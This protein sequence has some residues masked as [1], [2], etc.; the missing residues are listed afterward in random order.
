MSTRRRFMKQAGCAVAATAL[1]RYAFGAGR[2]VD[3]LK[4]LTEE[5]MK[6]ASYYKKTDAGADCELCPNYCILK[7]G[8]LSSC[9][10]RIVKGGKLITLAYNNPCAVH[11]DPVEKK[12]LNHF[13]PGT[14]TYSIAT[15]GCNLHC[16]NCQNW[17]ISQASPEETDNEDLTAAKG[18]AAAVLSKCK[19]ISYTYTE[20]I[21]FIEYMKDMATL[22]HTQKIK[23]IMVTAGY[24]NETPLRDLCKVIDAANVDL[25]SYDNE[26]YKKLN[27]GSL[28]PILNTLKIM[29]EE[30]VWL[31]ITNLI[32]PTWSDKEDMIKKMCD[33]LLKNGFEDT[34]LHFSRFFPQYKLTQLPPTPV[35]TIEN[36]RDIALAAGIKYVY[37]GNISG[38]TGTDTVCPKCK[39][40]VIARMGYKVTENNIVGGKCKFCSTKIAGVF[41]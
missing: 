21:V 17:S 15:A 34:P 5:N 32:V 33:W 1:A 28:D 7:E 24:I 27:A 11:I 13:L 20:P 26:V 6:E 9:R 8:K 29:K 12:P 22:A 18:V 37:V 3:I 4:K 30:G 10:T 14:Q 36:A 38:K 23:N 39:K 19:S 25:K 16:L 40:T 31:E 41:E 2:D 35:Q